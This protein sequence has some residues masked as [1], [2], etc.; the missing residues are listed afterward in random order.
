MQ[1]RGRGPSRGRGRNKAKSRSADSNHG[2][3]DARKVAKFC[4]CISAIYIAYNFQGRIQ[5]KLSTTTGIEKQRFDNLTFLNLAQCFACFIWSFLVLK[6]WPGEAGPKAPISVYWACSIS[7]TI[8]PACG[9]L[10]LKYIGHPAQVLSKSSKMIPV[11]LIGAVVY[12]VPCSRQEYLCTFTVAAGM[13]L[14]ALQSSSKRGIF[15][16]PKALFGYALCLLDL[17]LDGYTNASQDALT[18]R[19]RKV[20]AWHL[21]MGTNLWS[22]AYTALFMFL[23]PGGGGYD[24]VRFYMHHPDAALDVLMFCFCGAIGQYFIFLTISR[25]GALTNATI[26]STRKVVTIL[27]SSIWNGSPL[28]AQQWGGVVLVFAGLSYQIWCQYKNKKACKAAKLVR[29]ASPARFRGS[30]TRRKCK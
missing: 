24:A 1:T 9:M 2:A 17:G 16:G 4:F 5:E 30:K 18:T 15:A 19:Y 12:G 26:T 11:M 14:F 27:M 28:S 23:V 8:G 29:S 13:T 21:M 22:A 20:D 6:I 3:S 10:A 25:Y 7:N